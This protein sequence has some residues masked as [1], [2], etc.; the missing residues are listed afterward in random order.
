MTL[1]DLTDKVAVV[2]GSSRGIGKAIAEQMALHGAKI[3]VSSRKIESCEAVAAEINKKVQE[4]AG[5]AIAISCHISYKEQLQNLVNQTCE[6]FGKL[7]ILVCNAA[8]NPYFGPSS[9]IPD[10]AFD[11]IMDSNVKSKHWLCQ[12]ALC[13]MV[14]RKSG[15]IIVVSSIGGYR[16]SAVLGAYLISKAA[17]LAL[18]RNIAVEYGQYNIRA[19]AIAPGLIRTDFARAL[20]Y[21]PAAD[22]RTRRYRR[23]SCFFGLRGQW[24]Y[25]RSI[26]YYRWWS[27]GRIKS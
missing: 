20:Y 26:P 10:S 21:S 13:Q 15:S 7:D 4:Q 19:N 17:D 22:R 27:S 18:V 8:V 3:V 9:Q 6:H 12:M 23:G 2:T 14:A 11:K 24:F 25:D 1:F 16:G 5:E